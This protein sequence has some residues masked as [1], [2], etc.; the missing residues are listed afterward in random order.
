MTSATPV[1]DAPVFKALARGLDPFGS[2]SEVISGQGHELVQ[3]GHVAYHS[4]R[5][6]ETNTLCSTNPMSVGISIQSKVIDKNK[7]GDLG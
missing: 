1:G 2:R 6:D 3:V 7:A 4:M 5:L